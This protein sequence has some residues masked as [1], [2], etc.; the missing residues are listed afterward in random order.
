MQIFP[1]VLFLGCGA[2]FRARLDWLKNYVR[3]KN[4]T[5]FSDS[6]SLPSFFS[7]VFILSLSFFFS[8]QLGGRGYV[9]VCQSEAAMID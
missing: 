2:L 8:C 3:K 6:S 4:L 7:S 1:D 9:D 5:Q